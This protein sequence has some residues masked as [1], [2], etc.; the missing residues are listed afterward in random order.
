MGFSSGSQVYV[1]AYGE[2]FWGNDY[3]DTDLNKRIFPN[4]GE[5]SAEPV[6][7]MVP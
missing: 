5:I 6:M 4:L 7:F 1:K 3:E 2:S